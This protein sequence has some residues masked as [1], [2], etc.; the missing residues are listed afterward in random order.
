MK[1][2]KQGATTITLAGQTFTSDGDGIIDVPN[3]LANNAFSQGFVSAKSRI[4]VLQAAAKAAQPDPQPEKAPAPIP[5][6]AVPEAK[7]EL[8]EKK[9]P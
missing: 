6:K 8:A 1:I 9:K 7:P 3:H 2:Y 4:R 5:L